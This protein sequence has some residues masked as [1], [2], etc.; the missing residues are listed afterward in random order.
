ML[1]ESDCIHDVIKIDVKRIRRIISNIIDNSVRYIKTN[2]I[3]KINVESIENYYKFTISDNGKG[4]DENIIH[5]IFDPLFTTDNS[6]KTSGLG[7]SICREFVEMHGGTI[8]AYNN[9]GLTI[10]FTIPKEQTK[11]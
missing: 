11:E 8:K 9:L 10:E 7:L 6:R 5:K 2:G 4:V 3:I 1:I